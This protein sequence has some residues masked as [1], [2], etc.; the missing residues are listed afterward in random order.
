MAA[1]LV[2]MTYKFNWP[3]IPVDWPAEKI[4]FTLRWR[5]MVERDHVGN[6]EAQVIVRLEDRVGALEKKLLE[7]E[8]KQNGNLLLR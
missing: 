6:F 4:A 8:S 5:A 2:E 7:L 3:P 1:E